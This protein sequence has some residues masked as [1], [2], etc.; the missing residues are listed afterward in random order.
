MPLNG[1]GFAGCR[2]TV[3][4]FIGDK[5]FLGNPHNIRLI[6]YEQITLEIGPPFVVPPI[7]RFPRGL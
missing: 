3:R 2:G 7:Y 5:R 1:S 6:E 4:A